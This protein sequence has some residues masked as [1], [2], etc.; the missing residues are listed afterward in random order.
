VIIVGT[1]LDMITKKKYPP[2]YLPEL[3]RLIV[4]KYMNHTEP[5]KSGL[6][7][8]VGRIEISCRSSFMFNNHIGDLVNLIWEA[9]WEEQLPGYCQSYIIKNSWDDN[10]TL[11]L[12]ISLHFLFDVCSKAVYK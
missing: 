10:R 11:N 4:E 3:Q 7:R 8:V 9:V 1:H 5:E 6:P 12:L 2:N